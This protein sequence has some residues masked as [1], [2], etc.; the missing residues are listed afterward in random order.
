MLAPADPLSGRIPLSQVAG[1]RLWTPPIMARF[2]RLPNEV[3]YFLCASS[4]ARIGL[5]LKSAPEPLGVQ[6]SICGPCE[7]LPMMA[8][9]G[10]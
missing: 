5:S 3:T 10:M 8:P 1:A 4:G 7:V 6:L 2:S 9:C